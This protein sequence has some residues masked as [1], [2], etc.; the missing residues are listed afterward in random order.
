MHHRFWCCSGYPAGLP[1]NT[2][3]L[4]HDVIK[5]Y[6]SFNSRFFASLTPTE[7]RLYRGISVGGNMEQSN[8]A[9]LVSTRALEPGNDLK[10]V[11]VGNQGDL[12]FMS[13]KGLFRL[14]NQRN[15]VFEVVHPAICSLAVGEEAGRLG[16]VLVDCDGREVCYEVIT[17]ESGIKDRFFKLLG[18]KR[19]QTDSMLAHQVVHF[20][21]T[22]HKGLNFPATLVDTKREFAFHWAVSPTGRFLVMARPEK[23]T[24]HLQL[25]DVSDESIL[26]DFQMSL[27]VI[28]DIWVN[29]AGV[30]MV[31]V[32]Q[33][34]EEKL[35]IALPD[36]RTRYSFTPPPTYR[37]LNLGPLHVTVFLESQRHLMMFDYPGNVVVDVDMQPLRELGVEFDFNF[38]ERGD[39]DVLGW[40]GGALRIQHSDVKT[41]AVDAKRWDLTARQVQ[42]EQEQLMVHE[43]TIQHLQERK[44]L[45]EVQLSRQLL[46]AVQ[47]ELPS[48]P[49]DSFRPRLGGERV[50][51]PT[52][53]P[54]PG[55][56]PL[57]A[58]PAIPQVPGVPNIPAIP[59]VPSAPAM[60]PPSASGGA[61]LPPWQLDAGTAVPPPPPPVAP[62]PSIPAPPPAPSRPTTPSAPP[63]LAFLQ[64]GVPLPAPDTESVEAGPGL[65]QEV[66]Q[67]PPPEQSEPAF[68]SPED[69][70]QELER[71]RMTYIAGEISREAY[72]KRR[73]E[74]ETQRRGLQGPGLPLA[75]GPKRLDLELG[76]GSSAPPP[77]PVL[78]PK[79]LDVGPALELPLPDE[80]L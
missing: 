50:A 62:P 53:L 42:A 6:G 44:R 5:L 34:G 18:G 71:L 64:G 32:R 39:L 60:S 35:I 76:E 15:S 37:V 73:A 31:D 49:Q 10:L 24:Y 38:N 61:P 20:N 72:Y 4:W 25:I 45:E 59:G 2:R 26:A 9:T 21:V 63:P 46:D 22:S 1:K 57:P 77:R 67:E 51:P 54:P 40:Q 43:A 78:R 17:P 16:K 13:K 56:S 58:I 11:R 23:K 70:D 12:F 75:S 30:V 8:E 14:K 68:S 27:A 33:V 55:A 7:V 19:S 3:A 47:T 80:D 79:S 74:L 41:I 69:V 52:R 66:T 29:D 36:N 28:N 65:K 48:T